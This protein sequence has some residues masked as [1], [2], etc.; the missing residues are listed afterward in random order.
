[1]PEYLRHDNDI[2]SAMAIARR[3]AGRTE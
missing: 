3:T 2:T 1:L